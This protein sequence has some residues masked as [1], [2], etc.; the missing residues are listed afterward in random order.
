ML[1]GLF[2]LLFS[3]LGG[4]DSP[5]VIPKIE[6]TVMKVIVDKER[7]SEVKAL[8]KE[9]NKEWKSLRKMRKKQAKQLKKNIK[10]YSTENKMLAEIASTSATQRSDINDKLVELRL[11][12]QELIT[13]E[14]WKK[15]IDGIEGT[16]PKKIKKQEKANL[17]TKVKQNKKLKS[18]YSEIDAAFENAEDKAKAN[19]YFHQFEMI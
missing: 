15:I 11:S 12:I 18:I 6:K 8:F 9:F 14:E 1:V 19:K 7:K 13:S 10:N 17:K 4:S 16:K 2:V 3:I 5:F